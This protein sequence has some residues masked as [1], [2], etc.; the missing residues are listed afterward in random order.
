MNQGMLQ[1]GDDIMQVLVGADI[2]P[3]AVQTLEHLVWVIK[4]TCVTEQEIYGE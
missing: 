3:H 4:S 2:R 1:V